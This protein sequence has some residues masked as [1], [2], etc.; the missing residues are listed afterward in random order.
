MSRRSTTWPLRRHTRAKHEL[1]REYLKAWFP[2]L[3]A[4]GR[5]E[6]VLFLDGFA[7]PGIYEGRKLGSPLI[8]LKTLVT[9]DSFPRLATTTFDFVF[10]EKR[11]D[12]FERLQA[13]VAGFWLQRGGQPGNV[14][15][16]LYN[17]EFVTVARDSLPEL[18]RSAPLFAFV[19]PFGWK[20]TPMS[21]IRDRLASDRCEVLFTFMSDQVNRFVTVSEEAERYAQLFGTEEYSEA[22]DLDGDERKLFLRDLYVRQLREMA[23]FTFAK[24]FEFRDVDRGTR[25]MY[26]LMFG[27][28]HIRGLD[29]MKKAMWKLDPERGVLFAGLTGGDPLLFEPMPDLARLEVALRGRFVGETVGIED[30]ERFVITE[31]DFTSTHYK[32]PVLEGLERRGLLESVTERRNRYTYPPGTVLHFRTAARTTTNTQLSFGDF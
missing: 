12:R 5:E 26:F 16:H 19:D 25:T 22:G 32:R 29:R 2:I 18:R 24:P 13:E 3:S 23:G 14:R 28:N 21:I 4:N 17:E 10:V 31:T 6:R 9:H 8:A 11:R 27:T 15:V 7:G 20:G 30:I 1:M